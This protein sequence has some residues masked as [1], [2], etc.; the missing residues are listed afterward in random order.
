MQNFIL[1]DVVGKTKKPVLLK[2]GLSSN[3]QEWLLAAEYVLAQG[4]EQVILC[5]RGIRTFETYTRNT[6]DLSAIPIIEKVSHLPIIADPSHAT[7][8]WYLVSPLALAAVAAGA[9]GLLIEVHPNPD[10]ALAD[11]PQSLTFDNFRLLMSQLL[12]IAQARNRKLATPSVKN[13]P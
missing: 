12:P 6:M 10:M 5:E 13:K 2:R 3:I 11:G 4:N 7:G 8:K 1:L 9:D